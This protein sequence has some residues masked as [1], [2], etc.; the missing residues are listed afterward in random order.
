MISAIYN[1]SGCVV[2]D[3]QT[4]RREVVCQIQHGRQCAYNDAASSNYWMILNS[5]RRISDTAA[6]NYMNE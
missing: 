3:I 1:M 2:S 5:L 4:R 6:N